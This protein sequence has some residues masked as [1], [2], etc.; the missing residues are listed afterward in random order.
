MFDLIIMDLNLPDI[1]GE[2]GVKFLRQ[3]LGLK[4]PIIILSGEVTRETI[5]GM[6]S[7]GISGYVTKD[8]DVES[9]LVQE[10]A[11]V[12]WFGDE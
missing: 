6:A 10:V 12:L 8:S 1:R 3:R 4:T 11:G 2:T 9:N 7:L 5:Q